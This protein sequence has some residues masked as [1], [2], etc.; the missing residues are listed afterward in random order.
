MALKFTRLTR[1][2]IRKLSPGQSIAEHG[3]TF[4]R[5]ASGDGVYSVNIMVDG[6]R[7]HR[8]IGKESAR[9]TREQCEQFIEQARTDARQGRLNLPK[10]RKMVLGFKSAA[11]RYLQRL[12]EEGGK[13]LGKKSQHLRDHLTPFFGDTPLDKLAS[14]DIERYKKERLAS[15]YVS[16]GDR[17]SQSARESGSAIGGIRKQTSPGTVNRELATLSHLLTKAVEWGWIE[18]KP[19]IKKAKDQSGR[20]NY[21]TAEETARLLDAARQEPSPYVYPFIVIGLETSMR[22]ME[23]L[24]IRLQDIDV[25]RRQIAIP[26]AKAGARTQPITAHLAAFLQGYLESAEQGQEWLFPAESATGHAVAIEKAF[27]RVVVAAGLDP[28]KI[29]RHTLRHTAITHLVQAGVDL[30]TVQ[31]ISGHK[32]LQMVARYSHQNGEHIQ[33]ALSKLEERYRP[34]ETKAQLKGAKS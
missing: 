32:T 28:A 24:S 1:P 22:K 8:R 15:D 34:G 12:E 25:K 26:R 10:G 27:R 23:I 21:L 20:F 2:E 19:T 18:H 14:F 13:N 17:T 4:E 11:Q 7:I 9:V 5:L 6:Q 31:R 3:I 29:V 33:A 16:G 30:P